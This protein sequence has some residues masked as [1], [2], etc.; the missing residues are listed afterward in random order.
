LSKAAV[1]NFVERAAQKGLSWLLPEGLDDEQLERLL[2]L[3]GSKVR[4]T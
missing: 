4:V 2:C 3:S 1:A